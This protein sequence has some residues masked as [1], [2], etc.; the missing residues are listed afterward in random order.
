M[1]YTTGENT[2]VTIRL[3]ANLVLT[4]EAQFSTKNQPASLA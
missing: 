3:K 4:D 2:L 1:F